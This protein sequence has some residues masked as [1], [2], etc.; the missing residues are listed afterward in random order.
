VFRRPMLLLPAAIAALALPVAPAL[1]GEPDDDSDSGT[2]VLHSSQGCVHGSH[3]KARV[4][5]DNIDNVA[6]YVDGKLV[7]IVSR[8]GGDGGYRM[9]MRCSRL[10]V[11]AHTARAAVTFTSGTSPSRTTLRFQITRVA[12]GSARFTG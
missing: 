3:A 9:S 4:T 10:S 8:A 5:G 2:A 6:F 12:H 1:A 11:G 7:K